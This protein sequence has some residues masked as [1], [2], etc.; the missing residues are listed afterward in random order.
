VYNIVKGD[1]NIKKITLRFVG[2]GYQNKYQAKVMVY[3]INNQLV[4]DGKT[5]NGEV[6]LSVCK[7]QGYRIVA[8]FFQE[9]ICMNIYVNEFVHCYVIPFSHV[10]SNALEENTVNFLL[11]DQNYDGLPLE[12][13]ELI[14]WQR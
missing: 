4:F 10:I 9:V 5:Y 3:D 8:K 13:G 7:N 2:L 11:T 12:R 6:T 14:L 1:G